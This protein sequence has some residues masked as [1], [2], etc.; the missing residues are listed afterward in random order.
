[1]PFYRSVLLLISNLPKN[2]N[3]LDIIQQKMYARILNLIFLRISDFLYEVIKKFFKSEKYGCLPFTKIIYRIVIFAY[4]KCIYN[5]NVWYGQIKAYFLLH[6]TELVI[7][8]KCLIFKL[9]F[10]VLDISFSLISNRDSF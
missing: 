5:R 7:F 6:F 3:F 9:S 4:M 10:E 2:L 1:M 8:I